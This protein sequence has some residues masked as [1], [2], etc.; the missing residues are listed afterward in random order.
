[1]MRL[2]LRLLANKL[3]IQRPFSAL[4]YRTGKDMSDD[5]VFETIAK[6]GVVPVIALDSVDAA[7]PLADALMEGGLPLVEITFRTSV[8]AEVIEKMCWQRPGLLVGA[9]TVVTAESLRTAKAAGA[10]FGVAPGLNGDIVEGAKLAALPFV[11]GVCTPSDIERALALDCRLLKFFPAEA[12]GGVEMLKALSAPYGHLGVRFVPTG[13]VNMNNLA[14]Y[15][16]VDTVAAVGGTWIAKK[17]D[18]AAGNWAEIRDRCK[19]AVDIVAQVR[20]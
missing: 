4:H 6:C 11:P 3:A 18:L 16:A 5:R 14:A 17:E 10:K 2:T 20:G 1:L 7:I 8:A 12:S 15:L 9:G 13:G 19:K